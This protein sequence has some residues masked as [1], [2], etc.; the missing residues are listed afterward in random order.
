MAARH[1]AFL[2]IDRPYGEAR[3]MDGG[4]SAWQ[5]TEEKKKIPQ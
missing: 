1:R 5:A 4:R 2:R 3:G